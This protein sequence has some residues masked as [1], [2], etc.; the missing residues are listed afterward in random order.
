V[1]DFNTNDNLDHGHFDKVINRV[2]AKRQTEGGRMDW[3]V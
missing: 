1:D 3:I 2:W